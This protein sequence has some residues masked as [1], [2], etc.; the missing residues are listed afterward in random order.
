MSYG[1][2]CVTFLQF[3]FLGSSIKLV[4]IYKNENDSLTPPKI[5]FLNNYT[6]Y[7]HNFGHSDNNLNFPN[8]YTILY[9]LV[10]FFYRS[11]DEI[12]AREL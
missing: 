4:N 11:A 10:F 8:E 3:P 9:V 12:L 6:H 2:V 5:D 1:T 7:S